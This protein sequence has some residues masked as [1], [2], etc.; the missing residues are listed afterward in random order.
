MECRV[1]YQKYEMEF[2]LRD[3][4][5]RVNV[6]Y[7]AGVAVDLHYGKDDSIYYQADIVSSHKNDNFLVSGSSEYK[8][9][10]WDLSD[11][12]IFAINDGKYLLVSQEEYADEILHILGWNWTNAA[13]EYLFNNALVKIK[14]NLERFLKN[15]LENVQ[16]LNN[17]LI[18]IKKRID[19]VF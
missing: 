7:S 9:G 19:R 10:K 4:H 13:R 16:E 18:L 6:E 15:G 3:I 12:D 2:K 5:H 17:D 8:D 11:V 1:Y 14:E